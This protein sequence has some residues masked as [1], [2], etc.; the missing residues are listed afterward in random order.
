MRAKLLVEMWD[1]PTSI[2]EATFAVFVRATRRLHH[3][4]QRHKLNDLQF[5]HH[6]P[7]LTMH[8]CE[9]RSVHALVERDNAKPTPHCCGITG[10]LLKL[11]IMSHSIN[12]AFDSRNPG[13]RPTRS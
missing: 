6:M 7:P 8:E 9:I 13:W 2:F 3:A 11:F 12:D 5:P 10:Y 1:H 4:I